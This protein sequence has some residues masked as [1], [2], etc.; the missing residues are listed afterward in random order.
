MPNF[1]SRIKCFNI[2]LTVS[3]YFMTIWNRNLKLYEYFQA[4]ALWIKFHEW[5]RMLSAF[6]ICFLFTQ[7]TSQNKPTLIFMKTYLFQV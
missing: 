6:S 1:P 4:A 2:P 3:L 7:F 5:H